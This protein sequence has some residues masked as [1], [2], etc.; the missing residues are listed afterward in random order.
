M[1]LSIRPA[2]DADLPA[3]TAIYNDAGVGT[4]ASYDLEPVSLDSRRSW[5]EQ[6]S[7]AGFPI[8]VAELDGRI[9]GYAAYGPFRDKAGYAYTVEHSVYV[10][11]DA[12]HSG[13]GH[14]LM[15]DLVARARDRGVHAMVG[16]LDADNAASIAFHRRLGFA[17]V[18]R[19]PQVGRKF[20][21]WLDV[22]MVQLT[23]PV[24]DP[25]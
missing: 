3:I 7:A 11:R 12:R 15:A 13:V 14:A 8:V 25:D 6:R 24:P 23:L 18:A 2:A 9:V 5:F 19:L 21:R 22:V 1:P 10:T 4:T 16:V 20:G 17:E